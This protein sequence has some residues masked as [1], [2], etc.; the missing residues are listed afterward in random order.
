VLDLVRLGAVVVAIVMTACA[1]APSADTAS[2][3]STSLA[4]QSGNT[5]TTTGTQEARVERRVGQP[6]MLG[7]VQLTVLSLH[8]PF[9]STAKL[10]QAAARRQQSIKYEGRDRVRGE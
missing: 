4:I 6:F 10:Q 1:E 5:T 9:S 3:T 8:D 7:N 2:Q